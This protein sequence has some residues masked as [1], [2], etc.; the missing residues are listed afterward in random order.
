VDTS[1]TIAD[2]YDNLTV[3]K[4]LINSGTTYR[5]D[6]NTRGYELWT[7]FTD[8]AGCGFVSS[9]SGTLQLT[10][11][12]SGR[13]ANITTADPVPPPTNYW[14]FNMGSTSLTF[15]NATIT[16]YALSTASTGTLNIANMTLQYQSPSASYGFWIGAGATLTK[17]RDSTIYFTDNVNGALVN[18]VTNSVSTNIVISNSGSADDIF[19]GAYHTEYIDSNFD[20]SKTYITT[21]SII[22]F[23]HND[24]ANAYKII[25]GSSA[26][27]KSTIITDYT[28]G[29]DVELVEGSFTIDEASAS[30][31]FTTASGT[32]LTFNTGITHTF[33]AD[34]NL[35]NNG[36]LKSDGTITTGSGYFDLYT[37]GSAYL[38]NTTISNVDFN[39]YLGGFNFTVGRTANSTIADL[40]LEAPDIAGGDTAFNITDDTWNNKGSGTVWHM[41]VTATSGSV[42]FGTDNLTASE[43]YRSY[44]DS[45]QN[46]EGTADSGGWYNFTY[47]GWSTKHIYLTWAVSGP[48]PDIPGPGQW[49]RWIVGFNYSKHPFTNEV[50]LTAVFNYD[51]NASWYIWEFQDGAVFESASPNITRNFQFAFYS[52]ENVKLTI[53]A[54]DGNRYWME[55]P[56]VLDN[57]LWIAL[58]CLAVITI[59]VI[60]ITHTRK[61]RKK[62]EH[63]MVEKEG[64]G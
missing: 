40:T 3:Y 23:E 51:H 49:D 22:S 41:N 46:T 9:S 43:T 18:Y 12:S 33:D 37:P 31:D 35:T 1:G 55:S 17:F 50:R 61:A 29:S 19:T 26:L 27:S 30:D 11:V 47:S 54:T 21:G 53:I 6:A 13:G 36:L 52:E 5:A 10:G 20:K 4:I 48:T 58:L 25:V 62:T 39:Y 32:T 57:T 56:V 60:L 42:Y 8:V 2:L 59:S 45:V 34:A 64:F 16:Y 7:N 14:A 15:D 38:N 28:S 63:V 24:I 44:V